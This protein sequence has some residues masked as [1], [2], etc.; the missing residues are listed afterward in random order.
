MK[1]MSIATGPHDLRSIDV[2]IPNRGRECY[3]LPF[4]CETR[5]GFILV[6]QDATREKVADAYYY[7]P[8]EGCE[9]AVQW[10]LDFANITADGR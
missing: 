2:Y 8:E 4:T 6:I 3:T 5:H 9:Q 7:G 10:L 1:P